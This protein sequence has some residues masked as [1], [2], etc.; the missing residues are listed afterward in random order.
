ME[1]TTPAAGYLVPSYA[2]A[3]TPGRWAFRHAVNSVAAGRSLHRHT[4][5]QQTT[6]TPGALAA[7]C[8]R[9]RCQPARFGNGSIPEEGHSRSAGYVMA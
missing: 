7:G 4:L 9:C 3:G 8:G 6:A 2:M 1:V 5:N